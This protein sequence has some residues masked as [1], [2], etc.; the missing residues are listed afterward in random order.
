MTSVMVDSLYVYIVLPGMSASDV[1][2]VVLPSLVAG[3]RRP[4]TLAVE[5]AQVQLL[6][7]TRYTLHGTV[8]T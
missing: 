7:P 1:D 3:R 5:R 2:G 6:V 4:Q 8:H